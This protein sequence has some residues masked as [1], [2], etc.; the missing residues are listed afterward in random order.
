MLAVGVM[1]NELKFFVYLAAVAVLLLGAFRVGNEKVK[2]TPLGL[3]LF[4]FPMLWDTFA[5]AFD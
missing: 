1:S 3:A 5:L 2:L 4:V